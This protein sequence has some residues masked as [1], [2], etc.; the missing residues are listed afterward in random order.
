MI[1]KIGRGANMYGVLAY[2]LNKVHE[3]KAAII[4]LRNMLESPDGTYS[5]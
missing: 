2:N 1:A 4:H 3:H 5:T